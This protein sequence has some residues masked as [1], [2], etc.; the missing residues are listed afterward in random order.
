VSAAAEQQ[1]PHIGK[2]GTY[3]PPLPPRAWTLQLC[4]FDLE[5][6]VHH[7]ALTL[8]AD[9]NEAGRVRL[10]LKPLEQVTGNDGR[11]VRKGLEKLRDLGLIELRAKAGGRGHP[12]VWQLI[13]VGR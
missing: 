4:D 9:A 3:A 13:E 5:P 2:S 10:Y 6:W 8:A 1:H 11:R 7:L 12:S